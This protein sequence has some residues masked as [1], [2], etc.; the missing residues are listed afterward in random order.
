MN[1]LWV[2]VRL[3]KVLEQ[4]KK[5]LGNVFL[6][7]SKQ[8]YLFVKKKEKTIRRIKSDEKPNLKP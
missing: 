3:N 7:N 6:V 2:G 8:A 5:T 1:C 4:E